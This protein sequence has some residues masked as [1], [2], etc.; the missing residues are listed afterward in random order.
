MKTAKRFLAVLLTICLIVPA[1]L[2][3]GEAVHFQDMH[4]GQD[5]MDL[6]MSEQPNEIQYDGQLYS[7]DLE[8]NGEGFAS[9]FMLYGGK[10]HAMY[11]FTVPSNRYSVQDDGNALLL[12][13]F[14]IPADTRTTL[15]R[16]E[17]NRV[18]GDY[19]LT[20]TL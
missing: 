11:E 7:F 3:E 20:D 14:T 8:L 4:Y 15:Y 6:H 19:V 13:V 10:V 17:G 18:S 12:G 2:A 1:A 16:F 5:A 9:A